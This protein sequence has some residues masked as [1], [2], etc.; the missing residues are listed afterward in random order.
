[1]EMYLGLWYIGEELFESIAFRGLNGNRT[2]CLLL[3]CDF[4]PPYAC[5]LIEA[6]SH[7]INGR[8]P[9][10]IYPFI[11]RTITRSDNISLPNN[12]LQNVYFANDKKGV[13]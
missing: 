9:Y 11:F 4:A 7:Y 5:I 3:I 1:M 2:F 6:L 8:L 13:L 10:R 12:V